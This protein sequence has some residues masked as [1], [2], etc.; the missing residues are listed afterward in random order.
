MADDIDTTRNA[1]VTTILPEG[2]L[3]LEEMTG[4]EALGQAF[5]YDLSL[6][7]LD[8]NVDLT[9]LLGTSMTVHVVLGDGERTFNGIVTRAQFL[10]ADAQ[11]TRY[12]VTLQP[13]LWLLSYTTNC[14]IFQG[15]SVPDIIKEVFRDAGFSDFKE[16]LG[17]YDKREFC[18]QYNESD[19]DFVN[20]LMEDE[21]IYY[22]FE[23]E[24]DKHTLVMTDSYA[25]HA[26]TKGFET[27]IYRPP[28]EH[29]GMEREHLSR[30]S[31]TKQIRSGSVAANDFDF[32]VPQGDLKSRLAVPKDHPNA[33]GALY[34]YPGNYL[35]KDAGQNFVKVR[36]EER[37]VDFEVVD[38]GGDVRGLGAGALFDFTEYP[39]DD[40]NKEY[41]ILTATYQIHGG[42]FISGQNNAGEEEFQVGLTLIDSKIAFRPPHHTH[43]VRIEGPQTATVVGP[44]S[45]EI[46]TDKYGR[47]KVR[48]HWDH[49]VTKPEEASCY[50]RVSQA[51]AGAKWG[52]M[53]IPRIHQEVIVDF[54]E[55][56]PDRPIITGRV[57]N[58]DQMPPYDLPDNKTQSGI[59]SRST[60]KGGPTN[61]NEIRFE[62]KKGSEELFIQ[63]EKT[64]TTKVK[65]SQSISVD[66]DRSVSVGG[67]LSLTVTGGGKSAVHST[68][69]VTGKHSL[70]AS[71]TIEIDAPTHIKLTCGGSFILMEPGK[72]TINAGGNAVVVLDANVLAK[73]NGGAQVLLDANVLAKSNAGSKV[74]LDANALTQSSGGSQVMLDANA[75]L[76]AGGNVTIDGTKIQVTGKAEA[77]VSAGSGSVK[78]SGPGVEISGAM[79]KVNG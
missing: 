4:H 39:R 1:Y 25:G 31:L 44:D 46:W 36:L 75:L 47:V 10:G 74:V 26:K 67:N 18:V 23:H 62:D 29:H 21:G 16:V 64:Q 30:W 43:K 2:R 22:F 55:G 51:W 78:A 9:A 76:K 28:H 61:F 54:L 32:M 15:K 66:G 24:G 38:A 69:S 72:I 68:H 17:H 65:G 37:Q 35:T 42:D 77:T 79:V 56:D 19:F 49:A 53:H 59:K 60:P 52:S 7:S 71:D 8:P 40:Q 14:R 11:Y 3:L 12:H 6:L 13:W 20:R 5:S 73:A 58:N 63:A 45:E 57:Y 34:E 33:N 70:H 48:F 41:L 50:V 27:I